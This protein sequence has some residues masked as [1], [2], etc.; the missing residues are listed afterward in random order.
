MASGGRFVNLHSAEML[1]I[2]DESLSVL[3]SATGIAMYALAWFQ[4][5]GGVAPPSCRCRILFPT[6][7]PPRSELDRWNEVKTRLK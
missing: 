6:Q 2:G 4:A 7:F 3:S 5:P 1:R